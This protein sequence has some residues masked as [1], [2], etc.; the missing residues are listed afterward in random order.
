MSWKTLLL[1]GLVAGGLAFAPTPSSDA[2]VSVGIGLGFPVAYSYP[3]PYYPYPYGYYGPSVYWGPTFFWRNGH[4]VFIRHRGFVRHPHRVH[5]SSWRMT[6]LPSWLGS[7]F[8]P[9]LY[10][11]IEQGSDSGSPARTP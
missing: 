10:F 9:A 6:N 7:N 1:I 3:Y 2:G 8:E 11:D 5:R 4:R